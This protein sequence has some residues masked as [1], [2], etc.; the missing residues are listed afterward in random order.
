MTDGDRTITGCIRGV[1]TRLEQ[2]LNNV[3]VRVW[4]GL[5]QLDLVMQSV[6]EAAFDESFLSKMTKLIRFLQLQENLVAHM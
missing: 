2:I 5:H 3:I 4:C 6:F 1:V